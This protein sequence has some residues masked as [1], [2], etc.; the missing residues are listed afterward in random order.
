MAEQQAHTLSLS[1][2][3]DVESLR[4]N[5]SA[6]A[7][8]RL[9]FRLS[10]LPHCLARLKHNGGVKALAFSEDAKWLVT[11][12]SKGVVTVWQ[13]PGG[14]QLLNIRQEDGWPITS[15]RLSRDKRLMAIKA[16]N[17]K[18]RGE[19][20]FV[21]DVT[22]RRE[23]MRTPLFFNH[24]TP[25]AFTPDGKYL[26]VDTRES[27]EGYVLSLWD[28]ERGKVT[29]KIPLQPAAGSNNYFLLSPN[30][31]YLAGI[32]G[33]RLWIRDLVKG[34]SVGEIFS[35]GTIKP[36]SFSGNGDFLIT[37]T[38]GYAR[39]WEVAPPDAKARF[40]GDKDATLP[41]KQTKAIYIGRVSR[42]AYDPEHR[43]L[44]AVQDRAVRIWELGSGLEVQRL[45]SEHTINDV[46]FSSD[47]RH[48]AV[49]GDDGRAA[50]CENRSRDRARG[51]YGVFITERGPFFV[52]GVGTT[53]AS[54]HDLR[55]GRA[56]REIPQEEK[57]RALALSRSGEILAIAQGKRVSLWDIAK[58][59]R[60]RFRNLDDVILGLAFS[61]RSNTLALASYKRVEILEVKSGKITG[62]FTYTNA[63]PI[64]GWL[65]PGDDALTQTTGS[66]TDRVDLSFSP[67]GKL[68]QILRYSDPVARLWDVSRGKEL[69]RRGG[70]EDRLT[71]D[72]EYV[73]AR[74]RDQLSVK[75]LEG[76]TAFRT[77]LPAGSNE[78][79]HA[80]SSD[81]EQIAVSDGHVVEIWNARAGAKTAELAV[82]WGDCVSMSWMAL[83]PEGKF[84]ATACNR[85]DETGVAQ[86][87]EVATRK[88]AART[89]HPGFISRVS[90]T[91]DGKL[92][93]IESRQATRAWVWRPEELV[94]ETCTRLIRKD[95]TR[96][97]WR[98]YLGDEPYRKTCSNLRSDK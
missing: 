52:D 50:I 65:L 73:L 27:T 82:D 62:S 30:G 95:L 61:P 45:T 26:M 64:P 42:V 94:R 13:V 15:V 33:N 96:E 80:S 98:Q 91:P 18:A 70:S 93:I 92:L 46:G 76:K 44:A 84:L 57:I 74:G 32:E 4:R 6:E 90:F 40:F 67:N 51:L 48:L 71:A 25:L 28:I 2:L 35:D 58:A 21:W 10:L 89:G 12:S 60:I 87:W 88:L 34:R 9:N 11:A 77:S 75:D 19:V 86:I 69:W 41:P 63:D 39:V 85:R 72:S 49:A 47:G 59:E 43:Y 66:P 36:A 17:W 14:K 78:F 55:S 1:L 5:P 37:V 81:G 56:I 54:I 20:V 3:L 16:S 31:K 97:E 53:V 79:F 38:D 8:E 24:D 68:L 83:D 22:A 29:T 7:A 23:V